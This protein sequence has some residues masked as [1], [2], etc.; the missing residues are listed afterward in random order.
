METSQ[1]IVW[2]YHDDVFNTRFGIF[3]EERTFHYI[4]RDIETG[5]VEE[6][7]Q[8]L[9]TVVHNTRYERIHTLD[10]NKL[11]TKTELYKFFGVNENDDVVIYTE[12]TH[13]DVQDDSC[14]LK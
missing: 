10:K 6:L 11:Y 7:V 12:N 4:I 2:R 13:R 9:I 8:S 1:F 5:Q 14:L 3:E